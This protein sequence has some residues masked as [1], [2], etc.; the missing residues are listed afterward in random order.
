M[1]NMSMTK[2]P[3]PSQDPKVRARNYDEVALGLRYRGVPEED[4]RPRVER[5]LKVCGLDEFIEWPISALSF[6]QKKRVTIAAILVLEPSIMILDEP[7]AGQDYKHYTEIM[8]FLEQIN[9]LGIT[10]ILVTHDMH[11]M[12]E[13]TSRAIVMN[14]SRL[15][16][17]GRP[18]DILT[19]R[20]LIESANLKETSLF[21][22]CEKLGIQDASRF[23]QNFIDFERKERR[24]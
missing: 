21:T 4:I 20:E 1:A 2:N 13:Y 8:D 18:S 6:G 9:R 14:N 16:A 3:M 11:L 17:S 24:K 23:I 19:N 5:A 15:L 10:V 7:T 12:Q 22:L